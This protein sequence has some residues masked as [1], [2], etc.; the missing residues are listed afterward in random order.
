MNNQIKGIGIVL[1]CVICLS[2]DSLIFRLLNTDVWTVLFWRGILVAIG[3]FIY[4]KISKTPI[5]NTV[6]QGGIHSLMIIVFDTLSNIFFY[7]ALKNTSV[8]N[9][10][11]ILSTVPIFSAI[12]GWILLKDKTTCR[13]WLA[14]FVICPSVA[15]LFSGPQLTGNIIGDSY[16]LMAAI[17]LSISLICIR[18]CRHLDMTPC[19]GI[20]SLTTSLAA[21]PMSDPLV[22]LGNHHVITLFL[23]MGICSTLALIFL[24]VSP[25]YI[26]AAKASLFF[27]LETVLGIFLVAY[28]LH[29][30][31][32]D[33]TLVGGIIIMATIFLYSWAE[34]RESVNTKTL[35]SEHEL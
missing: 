32:R 6:L 17:S 34:F 7:S 5:L 2:P 29:E 15:L 31:I 21:F 19:A 22:V 10:L 18:Q 25:R 24:V 33:R 16:A 27:P 26:S 3:I 1:L 11:F 13:T 9:T 20:A 8:A 23:L 12:L 28:F 35:R 30:P 14:I 4:L